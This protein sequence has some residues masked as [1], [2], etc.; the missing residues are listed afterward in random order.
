MLDTTAKQYYLLL[1][2]PEAHSSAVAYGTAPLLK[3]LSEAMM[4]LSSF[5]YDPGG[6]C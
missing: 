1:L 2:S 4:D 5:L 3:L 6:H